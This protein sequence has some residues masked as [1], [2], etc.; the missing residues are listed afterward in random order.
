MKRSVLITVN[1]LIIESKAPS[2]LRKFVS[3]L[4]LRF[5][6][7]VLPI[8]GYDFKRGLVRAYRRLPGGAFADTGMITP[9]GDLWIVYS[10]GFYLDARRF[11]FHVQRDYFNAQIDF[12]QQHLDAG[13]V[14][15]MINSPEADARASL[16][17]WLA[18]L[19]FKQTRVIPTYV[20]SKI[21]DVYDLQKKHRR[22][23]V[24]PVWGGGSMGVELLADETSVSRFRQTLKRRGA[25]SLNDFCF[26]VYREGDEKRL[27]LAGGEFVGGR[28][29]RG[30][31]KPWSEWKF[32]EITT[33]DQNSRRTFSRDL[34]AACHLCKLSG[35]SVGSV[36]F[37]GDEINEINGCG[38]VLTTFDYRKLLIDHRL[39][40]VNYFQRL[41]SSL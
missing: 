24:K 13:R 2:T 31:R 15:L 1:P 16:K 5:D 6:L 40:Y 7:Y 20:C 28:R 4:D 23:V 8:D 9:A 26:Q 29:Y 41:L 25:G 38:T 14:R 19:N 18:T 17:S 12:H 39:A 11:G 37:I 21:D 30:D 36:D 35:I 10:D 33:Y 32:F 3:L 27:W 22:L 34:D